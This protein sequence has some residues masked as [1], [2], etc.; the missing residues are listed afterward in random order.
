MLLL[1]PLVLLHLLVLSGHL[2]FGV[3]LLLL[4]GDGVEA[5]SRPLLKEIESLLKLFLFGL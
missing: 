2:L 4:V 3:V 1:Q 5:L